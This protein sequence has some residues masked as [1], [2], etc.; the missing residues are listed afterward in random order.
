MIKTLKENVF[1]LFTLSLIATYFGCVAYYSVFNID[2]T[3][4]ISIEDITLIFA[5][6]IWLIL[7][8]VIILSYLIYDSFKNKTNEVS[9]WDKTIKKSNIKRRVFVIIPLLIVLVFSIIKF[10]IVE[11]IFGIIL[12]SI[13]IIII[14]I[15]VLY[16]LYDSFKNKTNI[17]EIKRK[18]IFKL[19][20]IIYIYILIIPS[21]VGWAIADNL[22]PDKVIVIFEDDKILNIEDS[23]NLFYIGKTSN[24][25]FI[26]NSVTKTTTA[27]NMEKVKSIEV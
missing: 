23:T 13:I 24:Y 19:I 25:F 21:W 9:Y 3:S 1:L 15:S 16:I 10:K 22:K 14:L 27:Y 11:I 2:V 8:S 12:F 20:A 5:H 6:K 4:F 18:D 17:N 7:F 26:N